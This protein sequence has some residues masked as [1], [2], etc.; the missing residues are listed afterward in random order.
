MIIISLVGS[1]GV[2]IWNKKKLKAT[3]PM[4]ALNI[5]SALTE[6]IDVFYVFNLFSNHT[7]IIFEYPSK[8]RNSKML[9]K[10]GQ[11][12]ALA[13]MC[14]IQ[15]EV[16]DK[17]E[18]LSLIPDPLD[19][20]SK[21]MPEVDLHPGMVKIPRIG[22]ARSVSIGVMLFNLYAQYTERRLPNW[23]KENTK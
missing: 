14:G 12:L 13:K 15:V 8:L 17:N 9:V 11:L 20:V 3:M 7:K 23:P 5:S 2:S 1:G 4:E 18:L 22:I 21:Y 10:Y 6:D 16:I 19:F